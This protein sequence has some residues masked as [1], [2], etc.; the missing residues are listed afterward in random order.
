ME[1]AVG[2]EEW[3]DDSVYENEEIV[4]ETLAAILAKQGQKDKAIKMYESL[5]L[6]FPKKSRLFAQKIAELS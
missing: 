4:S 6:T 5:S 1:P 2:E 3:E